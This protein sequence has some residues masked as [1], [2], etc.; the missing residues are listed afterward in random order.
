MMSSMLLFQ[1]S[2]LQLF[3]TNTFG[4]SK[5]DMVIQVSCP[6]HYVPLRHRM[7]HLPEHENILY[8]V[9]SLFSTY[10]EFAF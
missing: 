3:K 9:S 5:G 7:A 4:A 8:L 2:V 6:L 10:P 1:I